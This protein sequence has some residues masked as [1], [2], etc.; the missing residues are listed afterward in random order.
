MLVQEI[1][2]DLG[3]GIINTKGVKVHI[4]GFLLEERLLGYMFTG[5]DCRYSIGV[6]PLEEYDIAYIKDNALFLILDND[7]EVA[8]Y[9]FKPLKN[10]IVRYKHDGNKTTTKLYSIRYCEYSRKYNYKDMDISLLFD[11]ELSLS[12][13]FYNRFNNVLEI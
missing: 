7:I 3:S 6:F 8:R 2:N 5:K 13:Y 4:T 12:D 10:D 11:N 9:K 1:I